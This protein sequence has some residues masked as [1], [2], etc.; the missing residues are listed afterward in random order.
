M[1]AV[2]SACAAQRPSM[3]RAVLLQ[4]LLCVQVSVLAD[5]ARA[6]TSGSASGSASGTEQLEPK[7]ENLVK[8]EAVWIQGAMLPLPATAAPALAAVRST[9]TVN[10]K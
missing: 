3:L 6:E 2:A 9:T 8:R 4:L 1:A 10:H 7:A 5:A